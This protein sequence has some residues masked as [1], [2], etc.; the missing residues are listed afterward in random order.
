MTREIPVETA[1]EL[2]VAG[3]G[4]AGVAA[5]IVAARQGA[6]VLLVEATGCLG[7]MGTSGLMTSFCPLSDGQRSLAGGLML[8]IVETLHQRGFLSP[9]IT[10]DVWCKKFM[11]WIPFRVEGYKL[12]LDEL[13]VAAGVEVRFFTELIDVDADQPSGRV[14]GAIVHNIDG[15]RYVRAKTFIDGTGNGVLARLCGAACRDAGHDTPGIMPPTLVS[16][17][18]GIDWKRM[19]D[20]HAALEKALADHF[21]K[22]PDR[23]LPG[24]QRIGQHLGMLN[25]GHVFNLDALRNRSMS[26]GMMFGRRLA[27]EY[28]AFYRKYVPGCEVM[29]HVITAPLMGVRESRC[30]QGEYELNVRDYQARRQFPDQIA[31][32]NYPIDIHVRD[33]SAEELARYKREFLREGKPKPGECIGLP[34]GM[35]VPKGWKNLWVAGRCASMD[36]QVHGAFR[37]QPAAVMMGQAAG[38]AAVQSM[39]TGQSAG[40][41][42]TAALVEGLRRQ[43]AHLPQVN[44]AKSMTR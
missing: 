27:Q 26:D 42:D 31:V 38:T 4:P 7:G 28:L 40:D 34:Y 44:L 14:H 36:V 24:M 43:G 1:Y 11:H 13:A 6:K 25:A 3:G 9:G 16:L 17:C 41:L 35:L 39:K 21:L 8:E 20:Q 37:V 18:A 33:T 30:V 15:Y 19:G 29:E 12:V 10:P 23:H 5:A 22:Q 2:A 32:Y